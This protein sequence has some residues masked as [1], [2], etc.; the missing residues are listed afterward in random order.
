MEIG[1]VASADRNGQTKDRPHRAGLDDRRSS[2]AVGA[3]GETTANSARERLGSRRRQLIRGLIV[4]FCRA[5]LADRGV[6]LGVN[7]SAETMP[8]APRMIVFVTSSG[9]ISG[10]GLLEKSK[11]R[12]GTPYPGAPS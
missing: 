6:F 2:W 4:G 9:S 10:S 7:S 1:V 11:T 5:P 12:I 3:A 8:S